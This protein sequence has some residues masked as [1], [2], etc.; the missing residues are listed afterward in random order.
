[1]VDSRTGQEKFLLSEGDDLQLNL[2]VTD[3]DSDDPA[4]RKLLENLVGG[5]LFRAIPQLHVF[6]DLALMRTWSQANPALAAYAIAS[7]P[8]PEEFQARV[9][10]AAELGRLQRDLARHSTRDAL[11]TLGNRRYLLLRLAEEFSRARR[12]RTPL[13][14]AQEKNHRETAAFLRRHGA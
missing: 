11:T 2:V 10:L 12:Y 1:M 7:P 3:L 8:Q 9:R 4:V 6:R 5:D 14:L 13:S